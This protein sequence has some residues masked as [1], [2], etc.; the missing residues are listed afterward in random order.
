MD[1]LSRLRKLADY[2]RR[3]I[4]SEFALPQLVIFLEVAANPGVTMFQLQERLGMPQG[5]ISRN[6]KALGKYVKRRKG[7]R[8]VLGYGLL[9]TEPDLEER[10]R[11]AVFLTQEGQR[12]VA[13]LEKCIE[14]F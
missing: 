5:S 3:N 1:G 13:E 4:N 10:S 7:Q 8:E 14:E 9:R 2:I 11:L 6:V 12:V